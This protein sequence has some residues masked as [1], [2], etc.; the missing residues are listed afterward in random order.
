[1]WGYVGCHLERGA[2]VPWMRFWLQ[3]PKYP[4]EPNP[5]IGQSSEKTEARPAARIVYPQLTHAVTV[6]FSTTERLLANGVFF[7]PG[8]DQS[9]D[10][11]ERPSRARSPRSVKHSPRSP[12]CC[13]FRTAAR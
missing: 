2:P 8:S 5:T 4:N 10:R 3:E 12:R 9:R 11:R 13:R 7:G 1:M 6:R